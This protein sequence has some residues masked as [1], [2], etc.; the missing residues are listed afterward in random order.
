MKDIIKQ[1]FL[2]N[3]IYYLPNI[4]LD[5][6]QYLE[7]S[8]HLEF[9]GGKWKGGKIK[10]FIFDREINDIDELLG[11]NIKIK[12]DVQFFET[13][14]KIADKLVELAEID[15]F[16]T[17]LEPS[18]GRGRIIKSIQKFCSC[19]IDCCEIN[20]INKLYLEKI[21]NINYLCD[22]FLKLN[23]DKL[24]S[25]IIA[26]PPFAKN[27]DIEHIMKMYSL[28]KKDGI[29][30]S[31]SSKH[32]ENSNNKKEK[33]FKNFLDLIKAEIINIDAGEFKESGT[34]ISSN[35]IIIRK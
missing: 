24:Y 2:E 1:G 34:N 12:K 22:D 35:I 10:G 27:Q 21:N 25:R 17:I 15:N 5:R 9:L 3:N 7:I 26:N 33:E 29:L 6:K 13:P 20:D 23:T 31:I 8:K 28:L 14:E 30:V 32:W 16:Q 11:N 4:Q 19:Q 18:A